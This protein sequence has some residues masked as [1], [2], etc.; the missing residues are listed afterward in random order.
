MKLLLILLALVGGYM[1]FLLHTTNLVLSQTQQ[2]SQ[3]YTSTETYSEAA[4]TNSQTR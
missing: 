4:A 3:T 1:Y 2:L